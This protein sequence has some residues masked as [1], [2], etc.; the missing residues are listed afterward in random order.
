MATA[1][2]ANAVTSTSPIDSRPIGA[3]CA[4][5]S[6]NGGADRGRVQQRR[7]D[8]GQDE[9][10]L[11]RVVGTLDERRDD[12]DGGQDERGREAEARA[13]AGDCRRH[14]HQPDDRDLGRHGRSIA[15]HGA[16]PPVD[17]P[18]IK[19]A[20]P[21]GPPK[22]KSRCPRGT[23]GCSRRRGCTG[24]SSWSP[25]SPDRGLDFGGSTGAAPSDLRGLAWGA[26]LIF[27]GLTGGSAPRVM[28]CFGRVS[29]VPIVGLVLMAATV[30][31][32]SARFGFSSPLVLTAVGIVASFVPGVPD[33]RSSPSSS[34]RLP[35]AAALRGRDRRPPGR[36]QANRRPIACCRSGWCWLRRSPSPACGSGAA[37]A[38]ARAARGA[39]C[40]GRAPGRVA[41]PPRW[42]AGWAAAAGSSRCSRARACSTTRRRS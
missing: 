36:H 1:A 31:G 14:Q 32:F 18:K 22:I 7:Q 15:S 39:G 10:G 4:R 13:E 42:P 19:A 34:W 5:M 35:A 23:S 8:A 11:Q 17:P 3:G 9:L 27:G 6:T 33:Y 29:E 28:R 37:G 25:A 26:L 30:A 38:P 20:A 40:G 16:L 12:A 21:R 24:S 2:T 41:A